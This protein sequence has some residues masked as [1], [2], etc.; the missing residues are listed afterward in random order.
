VHSIGD[1]DDA[2]SGYLLPV[3]SAAWPAL[4]YPDWRPTLDTLHM[5]TQIVGKIRLALAPEEPQWGQVPLYP[6]ARGLS[7]S[8]MPWSE[9]T[10]D[11]EFD[12][13]DHELVI[14]A[15]HGV[16]VRIVLP[17]RSVAD[18]YQA[19]MTELDRLGVHVSIWTMPVEFENPIP[20]PDDVEHNSYDRDAVARFFDA[21]ERVSTVMHTY[22][23]RFR[24]RTSPVHFFWG[25]FDLANTRYSGA[26]APPPPD[27]DA[28]TR[29]SYTVEQISVGFWPGDE[30]IIRDA[31]FFAYAYPRPER[32]A[33]AEVTPDAAAWSSEHGLFLLPYADVR[34]EPDPESVL[35]AFF[36]SAYTACASRLGW[37]PALVAPR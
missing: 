3:R 19:L 10:I 21:L 28:I 35:L 4:S 7:T 1:C 34:R 29:G 17:D 5:F 9:G 27:A 23:S 36:D 32:I 8:A 31:A 11:M 30:G 15:S 26:P 22:R 16:I 14:R 13:I 18:F 2:P 20:F 12:L 33:Q 6:T 25:T 24:A 37:S